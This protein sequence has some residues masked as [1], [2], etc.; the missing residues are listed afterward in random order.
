MRAR[1]LLVLLLVTSTWA[2]T[3]SLLYWRLK[4]NPRVIAITTDLNKNL[5]QSLQLDEL[6]K[7]TFLRQFLERYFQYDSN[8][9]W[10]TQTS[11]AFLLAPDLRAQRLTE[12]SRLKEKVQS[13]NISQNAQ[14]L[15]IQQN[16]A[17]MYKAML[18][19]RLTEASSKVSDIQVHLHIQLE[20]TERSME[21]PWGLAVKE[22]TFLSEEPAEQVNL[23]LKAGKPVLITFPCALETIENPREDLLQT[24]IT[25]LN[26]SELQLT[27][28][29]DLNEELPFLALCKDKEFRLIVV[30]STAERTSFL[31]LQESAA[32]KRSS[33]AI[34][35]KDV[36]D[37]TI[38]NVLGIKL[39]N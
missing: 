22:M 23:A 37:K 2:L 10:Q 26:V 5:Q 1:I 18:R 36:Y 30:K 16:T 6:E 38:E 20:N 21:N 4:S 11:L 15:H 24:K 7:L 32:Q 17:G 28:L 3:V 25:T 13:K 14:L 9:F 34:K 35:K 27:A 12:I 8:T 33:S 31:A 29:K 39:E 19:L